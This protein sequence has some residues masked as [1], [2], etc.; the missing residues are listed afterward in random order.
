MKNKNVSGET[1]RMNEEQCVRLYT[2]K[3]TRPG[4]VGWNKKEFTSLPSWGHICNFHP[5]G[6]D[7]Y[8]GHEAAIHFFFLFFFLNVID[9][10]FL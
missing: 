1:S 9:I 6:F 5:V 7:N 4:V 3:R 8:N 2:S 10:I